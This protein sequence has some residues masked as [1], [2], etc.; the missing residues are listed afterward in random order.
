MKSNVI[1]RYDVM[2]YKYD[3]IIF[4]SIPGH[5]NIYIGIHPPDEEESSKHHHTHES[6]PHSHSKNSKNEEKTG[7]IAPFVD[8]NK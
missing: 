5:H 1:E 6:K 3:I 2:N 7:K 8:K 4:L